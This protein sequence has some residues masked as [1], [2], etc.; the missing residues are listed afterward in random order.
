[1]TSGIPTRGV[2]E[3]SAAPAI[4]LAMTTGANLRRTRATVTMMY[5]HSDVVLATIAKNQ[6]VTRETATPILAGLTAIA[7][8]ESA[9]A[10]SRMHSPDMFTCL[11]GRSASSFTTAIAS[12][13]CAAHRAVSPLA[14]APRRGVR[15]PVVTCDCRGLE[16]WSRPCRVGRLAASLSPSRSPGC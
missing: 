15:R 4:T 6:M 13:P 12:T 2:V 8:I 5:G 11:A 16:Q 3:A 10:R 14:E 7:T 1:M 9:I